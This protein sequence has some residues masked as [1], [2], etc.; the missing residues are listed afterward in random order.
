MLNTSALKFSKFSVKIYSTQ[1][2][3]CIFSAFLIDKREAQRSGNGTFNDQATPIP[4]QLQC[5]I[6][7]VGYG[8]GMAVGYRLNGHRLNPSST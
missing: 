6:L 2:M 4:W 1:T 3:E 7:Y 5:T 8:E